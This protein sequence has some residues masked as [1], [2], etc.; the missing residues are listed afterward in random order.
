[1]LYRTM[2]LFPD[3]PV[4]SAP[5]PYSTHIDPSPVVIESGWDSPGPPVANVVAALTVGPACAEAAAAMQKTMGAIGVMRKVM[6][7]FP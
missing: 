3:L 7:I 5:L 2:V 4:E 6:V 1:M